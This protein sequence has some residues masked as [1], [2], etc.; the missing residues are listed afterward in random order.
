MGYIEK[1]FEFKSPKELMERA[2]SVYGIKKRPEDLTSEEFVTVIATIFINQLIGLED[3][4]LVGASTAIIAKL[5]W[6]EI[7][8]NWFNI[9]EDIFGENIGGLVRT[10]V[11]FKKYLLRK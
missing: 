7:P 2:M 9:L 5:Y 10:V 1:R 11:F 8:A 6:K 4:E 3:P